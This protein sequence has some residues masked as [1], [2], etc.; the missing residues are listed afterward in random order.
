MEYTDEW[1]KKKE[2]REGEGGWRGERMKNINMHRKRSGRREWRRKEGG[3]PGRGW[4]K[5]HYTPKECTS[6]GIGV[7]CS[8]CIMQ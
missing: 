3:R 2:G 5:M 1:V 6:T 7:Y 4:V 8:L